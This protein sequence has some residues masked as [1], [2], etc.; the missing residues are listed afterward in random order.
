MFQTCSCEKEIKLVLGFEF[1]NHNSGFLLCNF[2]H[3]FLEKNFFSQSQIPQ[4]I[5]QWHL[6][7]SWDVMI[8]YNSYRNHLSSLCF[9]G[10]TPAFKTRIWCSEGMSL[11]NWVKWT[12]ATNYVILY[13]LLSSI[14]C[15]Q[16]FTGSI[17]ERTHNTQINSS[18]E[19]ATSSQVYLL[20]VVDFMNC[21]A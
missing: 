5:W 1:W 16:A 20:F 21:V 13:Q 12:L 17:I 18:Q 10:S 2:S 3:F 8:V 4:L 9:T 19:S 14:Y 11:V 15:S 6:W 7:K